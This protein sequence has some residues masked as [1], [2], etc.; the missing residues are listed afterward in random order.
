MDIGGLLPGT[1]R[2]Q[3]ASTAPR[4]Q[5]PELLVFGLTSTVSPTLTNDLRLSYL[6]N[7]WQWGTANDPPQI[8]G[9][10]GAL[11]IAAAGTDGAEVLIWEMA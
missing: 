10:G 2:G 1:T 4:V 3:Y 7:W 8:A 5:T 6:W 11:E 9:L